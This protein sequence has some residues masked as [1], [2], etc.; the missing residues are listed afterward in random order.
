MKDLMTNIM[1]LTWLL[2]VLLGCTTFSNSGIAHQRYPADGSFTK[3]VQKIQPKIIKIYGAGGFRGLESYQSGFLISNEGHILT[4]WSY[5]LDSD[6]VLAVLD[7]GKKYPATLVGMDPQYEIAILKIDVT[8]LPFFD[9]SQTL[10]SEVGMKVLAFSNLYGIAVGN[11]A[12]SVLHGYICAKTKLTVRQGSRKINYDGEVLVLDAMSNN[13]GAAGGALVSG[14]GDLLGIL[15]KELKNDLT[16]T[17]IN[18]AIPIAELEGVV[19]DILSGNERVARAETIKPKQAMSTQF[20]GIV[21]LPNILSKTPPFVDHV[22]DKSPAKEGGLMADDLIL[23]VNKRRITSCDDLDEE[24]SFIDQ[25][26]IVTLLVQRGEK[27]MTL[28][29]EIE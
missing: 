23:F 25:E 21:T 29:L 15:G 19:G 1:N 27:L 8:E 28:D 22:L 16:G 20:L 6:I 9:L 3:V 13:P 24:L 10:E 4:S 5:V 17:W 7:D 14:S 26:D 11:E 2:L 12:S 18:Y